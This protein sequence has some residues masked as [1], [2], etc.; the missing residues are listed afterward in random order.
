[1]SATV[2]RL[3]CSRLYRGG[4]GLPTSATPSILQQRRSITSKSMR[5]G[6]REIIHKPFPYKEKMYGVIQS[7]FDKTRFRLNENSKLLIVEGPI[8]AGKSKLAK[9]LADELEMHHMPEPTM[10]LVYINPYGYDMR[11]LDPQLP[12][13]CKSFDVAKFC[14]NPSHPSAATFQI[15]MYMLRYEQ[16][17]DAIA[18]IL[19]TG[20]GVVLERSAF[21]DFIFFEAMYKHGYV[22]KGARSVYN[23]IIQNTITELLKPHLVIYLDVPVKT[24]QVIKSFRA[25]HLCLFLPHSKYRYFSEYALFF[26]F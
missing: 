26:V 24:I 13:Q 6:P 21:S 1:M 11:Q 3:T 2:L 7:L 14:L 15:Q 18:H 22:S 12:E 20:Q 16:Y 25:C 8:A 19:S 10:D 5:G 9:E 17:I 23:E 4:G